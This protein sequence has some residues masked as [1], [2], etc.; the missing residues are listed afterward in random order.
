L[1]RRNT[2]KIAR[3]FYILSPENQPRRNEE[4]E[5]K[6][7]NLRA[8]RFFVV[9]F[10]CLSRVVHCDMNDPSEKGHGVQALACRLG[11]LEN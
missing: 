5:V 2:R 4:R 10:H 6:Q 3:R 8:L 9:D 7:K 11:P 1:K